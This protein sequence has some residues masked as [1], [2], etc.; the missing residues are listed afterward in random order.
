MGRVNASRDGRWIYF[1]SDRTGRPQIWK[2]PVRAN[3]G[4]A[5]AVQVTRNGAVNGMIESPDGKYLYCLKDG[6]LG[7]VTKVPAEGGEETPVLPSVFRSNFAVA[8][9]GIYFVPSPTQNRYSIQCLSFSSGKITRVA[10]IGMPL[11]GLSLS[12]GPKIDTRSILY[13]QSRRFDWNLMLVEN[14]R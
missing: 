13:T 12:P 11:W 5:K 1:V 14:F 10:D 4:E 7:P 8:E 2:I 3:V 6:T 9:E